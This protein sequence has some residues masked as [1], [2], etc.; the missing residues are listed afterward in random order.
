MSKQQLAST[1]ASSTSRA[2][3][4]RDEISKKLAQANGICIV[5]CSMSDMANEA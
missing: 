3:D 5:S 2:F 4:L 1:E